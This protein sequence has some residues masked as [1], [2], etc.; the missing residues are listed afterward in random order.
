[1]LEVGDLD[2]HVT[3]WLMLWEQMIPGR[4][5]LSAVIK[6]RHQ[7]HDTLMHSWAHIVGTDYS[8]FL[9]APA[10]NATTNHQ[11]APERV[12]RSVASQWR[13]DS[14]L[15]HHSLKANVTHPP[16]NTSAECGTCRHAWASLGLPG[17]NLRHRLFILFIPLAYFSTSNTGIL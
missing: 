2:N 17:V 1:M 4:G 10:C 3:M 7:N 16:N 11:T 9:T 13:P 14:V 12:T 15:R 6:Q 5:W 8:L